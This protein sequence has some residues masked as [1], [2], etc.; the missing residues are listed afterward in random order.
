MNV[1]LLSPED[2]VDSVE[3]SEKGKELEKHVKPQP[4]E[5]KLNPNSSLTAPCFEALLV[6]FAFSI[7]FTLGDA[8]DPM[9]AVGTASTNV[10]KVEFYFYLWNDRLE[11][12]GHV[13][14]FSELPCTP[15]TTFYEKWGRPSGQC[16]P[17]FPN[18]KIEYAVLMNVW[19][20]GVFL[21]CI[22]NTTLYEAWGLPSGQCTNAIPQ[23]ADYYTWIILFW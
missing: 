11:S 23:V 10:D 7:V 9:Y 4:Q 22:P 2:E 13:I 20:G 8:F 3:K 14:Y 5:Q 19:A 15:N 21:P 16:D 12:A 6:L 18:F 17:G 1:R